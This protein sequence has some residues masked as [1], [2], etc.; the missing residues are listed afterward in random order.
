MDIQS[1]QT[2]HQTS[3]SAREDKPRDLTWLGLADERELLC[4]AREI[5]TN[6]RYVNR[7]GKVFDE[8]ADP[9]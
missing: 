4:L 1:Q 7:A 8:T 9:H 6:N 3:P 5:A 2:E